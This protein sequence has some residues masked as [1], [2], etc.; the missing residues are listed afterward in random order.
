[1]LALCTLS[2]CCLCKVCW[3][4]SEAL[5]LAICVRL[6]SCLCIVCS[7]VSEALM[8]AICVRI[9]SCLCKPAHARVSKALLP[10]LQTLSLSF[11][12]DS[13]SG[14]WMFHCV[15]RLP[16]SSTP[17]FPFL[18]CEGMA[19]V[20]NWPFHMHYDITLWAYLSEPLIKDSHKSL[21]SM[22]NHTT[23][24]SKLLPLCTCYGEVYGNI[25]REENGWLTVVTVSL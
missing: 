14:F 11:L 10:A 16:N 2:C 25:P 19:T 20:T 15:L 17:C 5:M 1:M 12:T 23:A 24:C 4:V 9:S 21:S 18:R 6:C 7:N 22:E 8:L 13:S 3:N